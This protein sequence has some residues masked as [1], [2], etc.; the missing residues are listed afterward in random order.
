MVLI[1]RNNGQEATDGDI[2]SFVDS[3]AEA[4]A[5][6][7]GRDKDFG[8]LAINNLSCESQQL[9]NFKEDPARCGSALRMRFELRC[10]TVSMNCVHFMLCSPPPPCRTS[11]FCLSSGEVCLQPKR[12]LPV[13]VVD[14]LRSP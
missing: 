4:I 13:S 5:F 2:E 9:A 11:P 3:L 7:R 8:V 6:G 1:R 14:G 10:Y 12:F